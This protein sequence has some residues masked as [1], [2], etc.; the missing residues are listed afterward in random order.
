MSSFPGC[1]LKGFIQWQHDFVDDELLSLYAPYH[2]RIRTWL[3]EFNPDEFSWEDYSAEC[4][5]YIDYATEE[6][7]HYGISIARSI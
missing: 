7:F 2:N 6:V 4:P 5:V 1:T 3:S